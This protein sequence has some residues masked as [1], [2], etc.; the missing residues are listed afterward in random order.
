LAQSLA[1]GGSRV[2]TLNTY[3]YINL[4]II[5]Y[6]DVKRIVAFSTALD[7][8]QFDQTE[9]GSEERFFWNGNK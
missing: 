7:K 1:S 8:L 3:F 6:Y 2:K 4:I 9:D 5:L